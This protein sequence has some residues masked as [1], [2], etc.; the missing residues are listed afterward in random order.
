MSWTTHYGMGAIRTLHVALTRG[1]RVPGGSCLEQRHS[2]CP[3]EGGLPD[4]TTTV[5]LGG[6]C[7]LAVS[8][9]SSLPAVSGWCA[10]RMISVCC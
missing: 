8:G 4:P 10:E 3:P 6:L 5:T 7:G 1:G 9:S 2:R